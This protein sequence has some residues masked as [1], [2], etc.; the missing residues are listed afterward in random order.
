MLETLL[1]ISMIVS[2]LVSAHEDHTRSSN[3]F[4]HPA[5]ADVFNAVLSNSS[6][7][8]KGEYFCNDEDISLSDHFSRALSSS[9]ET[10]VNVTIKSSCNLSK[11]DI[12]D[13]KVIDIWDC[14]INIIEE[15]SDIEYFANTSYTFGLSIKEFDFVKGSLRCL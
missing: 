8:L 12:T 9:Y 10:D 7:R 5:G 1:T 6:L 11:F 15:N 3:D 2:G 14:N 13:S 4:V